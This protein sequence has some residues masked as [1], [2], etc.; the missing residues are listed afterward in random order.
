MN[1]WRP[2]IDRCQFL[3]DR[4]D[5]ILTERSAEGDF[6]INNIDDLETVLY[7]LRY[8]ANSLGAMKDVN[9]RAGATPLDP[10]PQGPSM[11]VDEGGRTVGSNPATGAK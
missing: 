9:P 6:I 5:M 7:A 10:K 3:S 11:A 1:Q 8:V 4:I 2:M